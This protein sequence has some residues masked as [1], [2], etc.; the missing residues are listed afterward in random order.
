LESQKSY[1][2]KNGEIFLMELLFLFLQI[3]FHISQDILEAMN[4]ASKISGYVKASDF[5][6][7]KI[8]P[9]VSLEIKNHTKY[10]KRVLALLEIQKENMED[11]LAYYYLPSSFNH[12]LL[13]APELVA[14]AK[15]RIYGLKFIGMTGSGQ[16]TT[17]R[18]ETIRLE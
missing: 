16:Y 4:L 1:I 2:K 9:I 10:G 7:G 18:F 11:S 14:K 17:P 12:V 13:A 8:Y 5:T 6:I 15:N 3:I